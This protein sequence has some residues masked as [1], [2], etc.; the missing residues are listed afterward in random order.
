MGRWAYQT[1]QVII[2]QLEGVVAKRLNV[3]A[4]HSVLG[5]QQRVD[6]GAVP[7]AV[8]LSGFQVQ[9]SEV[10]YPNAFFAV[11]PEVPGRGVLGSDPVFRCSVFSGV[12]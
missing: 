9:P 1:E 10:V 4:V 12:Q 5:R 2:R 8:D 3:E 7:D 11:G 6:L